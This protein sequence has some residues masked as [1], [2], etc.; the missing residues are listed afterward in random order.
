MTRVGRGRAAGVSVVCAFALAMVGCG[1]NTPASETV[2]PTFASQAGP[3]SAAEPAPDASFDVESYILA[4]V[5][6]LRDAGWDA[7][8]V[9]PGDGIKVNSVTEGQGAA[10]REAFDVCNQRVGP[11]PTARLLTEAELRDLYALLLAVRD[12]LVAAGFEVSEPPSEDAFVESY[13]LAG[14]WDPYRDIVIGWE[15]AIEACPQPRVPL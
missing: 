5:G 13:Y 14:S 8:V 10:Y 3:T 12:C 9:P 4:M 1:S 2:E 11:A 6:C 15:R 7:E